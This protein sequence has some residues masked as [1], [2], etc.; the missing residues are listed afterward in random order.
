MWKQWP[1]EAERDGRA[2]LRIDGKIYKRHLVRLP[3]DSD[4]V[5]FIIAELNRKYQAHTTVEDVEAN[6]TW[7]FELAPGL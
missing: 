5:P 1:V 7:L 3:T 6:G 4:V 2:L